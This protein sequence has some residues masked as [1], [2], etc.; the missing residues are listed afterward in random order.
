MNWK[1]AAGLYAAYKIGQGSR[2]PEG[3]SPTGG[4]GPTGGRKS[5]GTTSLAEFMVYVVLGLGLAYLLIKLGV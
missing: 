3:P 4:S 5:F 2:K 1:K